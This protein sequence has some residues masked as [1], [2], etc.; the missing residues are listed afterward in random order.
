M[1]ELKNGQKPSLP[2][3]QDILYLS[4]QIAANVSL[5]GQTKIL[6]DFLNEHFKGKSHIVFKS[7]RKSLPISFSSE[8]FPFNPVDFFQN[9]FSGDHLILNDSD[10]VFSVTKL[11]YADELFGL[12]IVEWN[13]PI[14][15]SVLYSLDQLAQVTSFTIYATIQ[16]Q[17]NVWRQ[18]Q[19]KLVRSVS[20]KISQTTDLDQ[21]SEQ[22]TRLVQET[23]EFYYVAIFIINSE[24]KKLNF[25]ASACTGEN[26]RPEFEQKDHPGFSLGEHMIGYVA[27]TGLELIANNV[28]EEPRYK[29]V[30]SLTNTK[31]EAVIPLKVESRIFGVFDVQSDELNAF[32]EDVLLVLH[33]LA[34]SISLAVESAQLYQGLQNQ[35][36]QLS[37]VGQ[38]SRAITYILDI[39]E[40]IL[41]IV[42]IIHDRFNF[43]F[44]H[45]YTVDPHQ[46]KIIFKAGSGSRTALYQ[47]AGTA[48]DIHS[49]IG[50]LPWV[51][52]HGKTKRINDVTKEPLF[53]ESPFSSEIS[54]S[55]MSI[56]LTFAGNILGIL[57]IQSD[58]MNAFSQEDQ[59][60]ME[61]LADNIAIALR[62]ARLY[63]SENWRRKVAESM[64]DV[65]GLL[66]EKIELKDVLDRI[67]VQLHITLPCDIA[68]IWLFNSDEVQGEL[69]IGD[70][71]LHL[72]AYKTAEG[73]PSE[74]LG[75]ITFLPDSWVKASFEEKAPTIRQPGDSIGPIAEKFNLA[76][77]YS[78]I[79]APL[80]IGD[81]I[82]GMLTLVHHTQGRYGTESQNITSVFASYAAIA[83][84]N[85]RL[86]STS[87][88]QAWISTILLQVAQAT[89]SLTTI[90]ELVTTIVRLTPLVVGV[91]GCALFLRE[92]ETGIFSLYALYGIG[93]SS[94]NLDLD[95]PLP[96]INAPILDELAAIQEPLYV[97]HPKEDFNLPETFT[98]QMEKD[99]L[100]LLPLI[101][102]NEVLGAFLLANES[103]S[104]NQNN[105]LE[106]FSE[107]RLSI[108]R[109]IIQQTAVAVEN[110]RLLEEKQEEAYVS[111]VLLQSAQ[112]VVSSENL[113]DTLDSLVQIMPILVGIESSVI[114]IWDDDGFF[115]SAHAELKE[116]SAQEDLIGTKYLPGDFP[117]LDTVFRINN[118]VVFP[119]TEATLPAEDWDLVLPDDGQVDPLAVVNSRYPLLMGFP[120]SMHEDRFGVL[121]ASDTNISI[122]RERRFELIWGIAQQ[123]SLAIQNDIINKD[124]LER[125][126]LE[127]EFQLARDI[128]QTFLP[129]KVPDIP[130]WQIDVRWETARQVGGDFYDYFLLPDGRLGFVIADVSDK[131]L[132]ASLYMS[133]TR[134]LIRA[135]APEYKS[136]ARTLERVNDLLLANS[137][138]GL[139]VTTFYGV[140]NLDEGILTY[141]IA[142]HNPPMISRHDGQTV[143]ILGKGGIA[144]G[145]LPNIH[146]DEQITNLQA[147]D[148][149]VLYTDGVTEAFN[150]DEEMYGEARLE[151]NLQMTIGQGASVLIETLEKDLDT[152]RGSTPLSDDTT[153]LAIC[154]E[155]SLANYHRNPGAPQDAI[156]SASE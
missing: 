22:I 103:S 92:P 133:V 41:K 11:K 3:T 25:K 111:A 26:D 32:D 10:R 14:D 142:G 66:S 134:T 136:P 53:L 48:F 81:E 151:R 98:T 38:V 55:E 113:E 137:Q 82:L 44:V 72:A 40:L 127:R 30:D 57:D 89:Q 74:E 35:A 154:K 37:I 20:E 146:L 47:E 123:A 62:N 84:K 83:I 106:V 147:G 77:N 150:A 86:F 65:A 75:N 97:H 105:Q 87:Q 43:P 63:H 70:R 24:T 96:L 156:N 107:E 6:Q 114:Y 39:D 46:E 101:S 141:S 18:K 132:A 28:S 71:V 16:K 116:K 9:E 112:A 143:E 144:L 76:E 52:Q 23:F 36:T 19:L 108:I 122:N 31:S 124:V 130:G 109:G 42:S 73:Y 115:R 4:E 129:D 91:K 140:L 8:H 12:I 27:N 45:L 125:Q 54:G 139:F 126:H 2:S 15:E 128:Q 68:G 17:L 145:A 135:A 121:L 152:F 78:S 90:D 1:L 34:N 99:T 88:E 49:P 51:A 117:M 29:A 138:D 69:P 120:L 153:I 13:I 80:H 67:L 79:S 56:P 5:E 148:C 33:A 50:I 155:Q 7:P 100:I 21:L 94:D 93:E 59:Q 110:I 60:L 118:P 95:K 61:T 102:R 131:G 58:Q 85:T 149:L 104:I 64:R 119:F